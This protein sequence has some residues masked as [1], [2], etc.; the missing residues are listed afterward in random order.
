MLR[1]TLS[2]WLALRLRLGLPIPVVAG[3]D[4][5]HIAQAV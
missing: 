2:D 1:E 4:L 5:N 3:F